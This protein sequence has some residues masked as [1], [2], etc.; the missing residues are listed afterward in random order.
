MRKGGREEG[1]REGWR[2]MMREGWRDVLH[3]QG[4]KFA[5]TLR[6][7]LHTPT[8]IT[9]LQFHAKVAVASKQNGKIH[10]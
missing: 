6:L 2:E 4:W 7:D 3:V 8:I 5:G 9:V 1:V 10:L